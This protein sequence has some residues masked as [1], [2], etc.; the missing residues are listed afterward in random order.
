MVWRNAGG[1]YERKTQFQMKKEADQTGFKGT[2]TGGSGDAGDLSSRGG[3]DLAAWAAEPLA[4]VPRGDAAAGARTT[5]RGGAQAAA[6]V[7]SH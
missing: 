1:I 7:R 2:R 3:L 5:V 4:P 6:M